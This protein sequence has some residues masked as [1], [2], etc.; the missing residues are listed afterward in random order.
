M[1]KSTAQ[2]ARFLDRRDTCHPAPLLCRS[3]RPQLTGRATRT[4][5]ALL[6][7]AL[8][9]YAQ[10]AAFTPDRLR[11]EEEHS[12]P[13]SAR[14]PRSRRNTRSAKSNGGACQQQ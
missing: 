3:T 11:S 12:S 7:F 8:R 4:P 9:L 10:G 14:S 5:A 6:C 1:S 2:H 13:A